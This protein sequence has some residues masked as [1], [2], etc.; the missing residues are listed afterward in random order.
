MVTLI[1]KEAHLMVG[2]QRTINE[3]VMYSVTKKQR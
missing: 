3:F 2:K 1:Y